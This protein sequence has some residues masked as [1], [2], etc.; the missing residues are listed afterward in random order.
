MPNDNIM[1]SICMLTYNHEKYVKQ[2]VDS[3]LTQEVN[4]E[5]ELIIGDDASTDDT[6]KVLKE[7]YSNAQKVK[8]I[9]R[10]ENLLTKTEGPTNVYDVRQRASGKYMCFAEGDDYWVDNH[11]LQK[12]VDF[13]ENHEEYVGVCGHRYYLSERTG[14]IIN[15]QNHDCDDTDI[16]FNDFVK[17]TK[18]F[19]ASATVFRNF[20]SDGKYDYRDFLV[21]RF[22]GD[23]TFGIHI[24]LHGAI[25]QKRDIVGVYRMDRVRWASSYNVMN[26]RRD[27]FRTH[28][29]M[30]LKLNESIDD[31]ID[32]SPA[33]YFRTKEYLEN[34]VLQEDI[35]DAE[36]YL[37]HENGLHY[38]KEMLYDR[39]KEISNTDKIIRSIYNA[40]YD[41]DDKY[42]LVLYWLKNPNAVLDYLKANGY[43]K[44]GIYG[45]R[46]LGDC[47]VEQ[48]QDSEIE[49]ICVVDQNHREL[50]YSSI[51]VLSPDDELPQMDALV[52]AAPISF[53]NIKEKMSKKT[54]SPILSLAKII[55]K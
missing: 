18:S 35:Y 43:K 10:D 54:C 39:K 23:L 31:G 52:V 51:M 20:Y 44:I 27:I 28:V 26:N 11:Y 25:Y 29:K 1:L 2:M 53:E 37:L 4:F 36:K 19:D 21:D 30:L 5:Y 55:Y 9:L 48:L 40:Y 14:M 13:L 15:Q 41:L 8:L 32:L 16:T 38:L 12:M 42:R 47:L 22:V 24:L 34:V 49:V 6:Q 45:A 46:Y 3:I 7:L 33:I 50:C 17:G